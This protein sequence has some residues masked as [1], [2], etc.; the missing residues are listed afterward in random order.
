M[1]TIL[2]GVLSMKRKMQKKI[3]RRR[4]TFSFNAP[5]ARKVSLVGEFNNWDPAK[6]PM[7]SDDNDLWTK[8]IVLE[9]GTYNYKFLMDEKWMIDT[10]N[11]S[12]RL[13]R[14]GT[15]NS[16]ITVPPHKK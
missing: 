15:L 5:K 12:S 16:L 11:D 7:K 10:Q 2:K 1:N 6:H 14:Y 8:T 9:P 13:N 3:K 4:V